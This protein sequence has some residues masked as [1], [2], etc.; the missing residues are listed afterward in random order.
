MRGVLVTPGPSRVTHGS[1]GGVQGQ[2]ARVGGQPEPVPPAVPPLWAVGPRG[3]GGGGGSTWS[4]FL[5]AHQP[6]LFQVR[7]EWAE[8]GGGVLAGL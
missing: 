5:G 3:A 4:W 8:L 7:S 2:G 1:S 6:S